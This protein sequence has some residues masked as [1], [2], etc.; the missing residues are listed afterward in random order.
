MGERNRTA[1]DQYEVDVGSRHA[2]FFG[3]LPDRRCPNEHMSEAA[4]ATRGGQ[5]I[6]E[7]LVETKFRRASASFTQCGLRVGDE[8]RSAG[9]SST[10]PAGFGCCCSSPS[11]RISIRSRNESRCVTGAKGLKRWLELIRG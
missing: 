8:A 9:S 11:P 10:V 6:V 4:L 7:L 2:Q 1:V 3:D 5:V